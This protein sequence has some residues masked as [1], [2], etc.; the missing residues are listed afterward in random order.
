MM[1]KHTVLAVAALL[2]PLSVHAAPQ[3]VELPRSVADVSFLDH[4]SIHHQGQ[5]LDVNVLRNSDKTIVL[6]NDPVSGA[7]MYS[8]RSAQLSYLVDC[9]ARKVALTGWKMFEG[10]LGTGDVV[11]ADKNWGEPTFVNV[12]DEESRA[13]V[14]SACA[15][16]LAAR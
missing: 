10:N 2:I 13:V 8:H 7:A 6:G 1:I 5:F 11:W 16:L 14:I 15:S 3:W 9:D 12:T 4:S